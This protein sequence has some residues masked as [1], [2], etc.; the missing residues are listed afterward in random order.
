MNMLRKAFTLVELLVVIA[1]IGVLVAL[2]LPAVQAAREASRRIEC[3][4]NLKQIGLGLHNYH[5]SNHQLPAGWIA[6]ISTGEPGWGWAMHLLPWIEQTSL[7]D[8][9][10]AT[11]SISAPVHEAPRQSLLP[12]YRCSSDARWEPQVALTDD[13]DNPLFNVGRSNYVGVYGTEEIEDAPLDG[14]GV[15]FQNSRIRFADILDGLSNT[16]VVGE[17]SSRLD[18]S[19]WTGAVAEAAEGMA[20]IVGSADHPPNDPH[21]HFDDFS[22]YHATGANFVW[23]DGSVRLIA[24]T[25]DEDVY[26]AV[27]TRSGGEVAQI[28]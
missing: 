6:N 20:R 3:S 22:S 8:Q 26:R 15:F 21:A 7:H 11:I 23:G 27:A 4:N 10:D 25:I 17:R 14:D 13:S 28:D 16:I 19:T 1:V 24:S 12:F 5:D 18:G 2:L 9:M